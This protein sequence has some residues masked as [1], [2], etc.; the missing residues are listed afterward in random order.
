M[1][2][3]KG[4]SGNPEGRKKGVENL[5]TGKVRELFQSLITDNISRLK[6]DFDS[7][8]AK[9]RLEMSIKMAHFILPKLQSIDIDNYPEW[10]TLLLLSPEERSQEII[11]LKKELDNEG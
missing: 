7:L 11:K 3:S 5:A 6:K 4:I 8:T 10:A 9:E 2:F 1:P